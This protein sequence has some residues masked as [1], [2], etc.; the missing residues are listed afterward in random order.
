MMKATDLREGNDFTSEGVFQERIIYL[1]TVALATLCPNKNSSNT[2]RSAP[3][4]RFSGDMRRIRSR[5]LH[6]MSGR[7]GFPALDFHHQYIMASPA[8]MEEMARA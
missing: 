2:I 5:I 6:L 1:V 4:V 3:H 8:M 7:H